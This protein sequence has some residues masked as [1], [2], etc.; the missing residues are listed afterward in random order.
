[1][2]FVQRV[3]AG[4]GHACRTYSGAICITALFLTMVLGM[5]AK[6]LY[7]MVVSNEQLPS[8]GTEILTRKDVMLPL[9]VSPMV[10]GAIYGYLRN[11]P[12]TVITFMFAFQNG[13]FWKTVFGRLDKPTAFPQ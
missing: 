8:F 13:F 1:M 12:I 7:D 2:S 5:V 9:L 10:F 3:F 6:A 4:F 11:S